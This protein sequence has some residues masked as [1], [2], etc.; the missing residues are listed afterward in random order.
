MKLKCTALEAKAQLSA[1]AAESVGNSPDEFGNL[2]EAEI[3][4]WAR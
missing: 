2:L 1:E 3:A 4:G